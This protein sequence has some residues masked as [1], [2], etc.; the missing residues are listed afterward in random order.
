MQAGLI[1]TALSYPVSHSIKT[2]EPGEQSDDVG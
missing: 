1:A 2:L